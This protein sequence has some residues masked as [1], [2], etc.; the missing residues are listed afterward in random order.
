M[1]VT[2]RPLVEKDL[3]SADR[4]FRVTFGTLF[5]YDEPMKFYGDA[6]VLRTRWKADSVATFGATVGGEF[7]GLQYAT[8]WGSIG[9]F[10]PLAVRPDYWNQ[11]VGRVLMERTVEF[12][13]KWKVRVSGLTTFPDNS[14]NVSFYQKFDYWPIMF[15]SKMFAKVDAQVKSSPDWIG[16]SKGSGKERASSLKECAEITNP[17]Y[18]GLNVEGEIKAVFDQKLGE[19]VLLSDRSGLAAFAVCH[20]GPGTEAG[21]GN[22]YV[23]VGAVRPG[24]KAEANFNRLIVACKALA[25]TK[26]ASQLVAGVNLA[27]HRA[28]RSMPANG[29]RLNW[30]VLAMHRPN[31]PAHDRPDVY[32][33]DDWL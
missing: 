23:K 24:P 25:S 29:F 4:L 22:C 5:H 3:G 30:Q 32:L 26:G 27:R 28:Y 17:I 21:S 20:L 14:K 8:R 1:D 16:F 13:D 7:V 11:G 9:W 12:F 19:T 31:D 15:A 33:F 18:E 10:G 6:D 2:V